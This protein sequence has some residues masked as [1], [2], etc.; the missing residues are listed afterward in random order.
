MT[1]HQTRQT[2]PRPA[3]RWG[4]DT[5]LRTVIPTALVAIWVAA[6]P[7]HTWPWYAAV[8]A[9]AAA[10]VA[11]GLVTVGG[12]TAPQ[13]LWR[14]IRV[15]WRARQGRPL[16]GEPGPAHA[17]VVAGEEIGVIWDG[18]QL[19]AAIDLHGHPHVPHWLTQ[20]KVRTAATIPVAALE[21]ALETLGEGRP[22]S[23][24]LVFDAAR[25]ALTPY[26]ASYDTQLAGRPVVGER[27]SVLI[28]RF[29]PAQ[30]PTYYAARSSLPA[31]AATSVSRLARAI[32]AAGCPC[33]ALTAASLDEFAAGPAR[34]GCPA[35]GTC[36]PARRRRRWTPC[37]ASTRPP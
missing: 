34:P 3:Y 6:L 32:A 29:T 10:V 22:S 27:R 20:R 24:D 36:R 31:A 9:A 18:G 2:R 33:T 30:R 26:T 35:G 17:V 28:A 15:A 23:V 13:W 21:A 12:F 37:T 4:V 1:R 11:V 8:T 19:I 14:R 25:L 7:V 16:R 5:R